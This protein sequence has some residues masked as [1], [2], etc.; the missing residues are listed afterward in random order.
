MKTVAAI[1]AVAGI[2]AS[3]WGS[4][5]ASGLVVL[6]PNASGALTLSGSSRVHIPAA[7]VYVNSVAADAVNASGRAIIETPTLYLRTGATLSAQTQP[8]GAVIHA[9]TE[10]LDPLAGMIFPDAEAL[11][12]LG[13]QSI[14]GGG[15]VHLEPG[16]YGSISINGGAQ[17]VLASGTYIIGGSGLT[18]GAGSMLTGEHV[19]L[20]IES[21]G[22]TLTGQPIIE[23]SP[24][25]EG[26]FAGIVIAQPPGNTSLMS[27][28]GGSAI[29][30]GGV[31]YAP[32][33]ALRVSGS[34]TVEGDGP[35]VGNLLIT[36]TVNLSGQGSIM[37]GGRNMRAIE[38]MRAPL[39]D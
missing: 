29:N 5:I 30:I 23:L 36:R 27:I 6:H 12:S 18:V 21:G 38:L 22:L 11:P 34:G 20:V 19:T 1:V 39:Y 14:N 25:A 2:A 10:F 17:V 35:K 28:T 9:S 31:I 3:A 37:I 15:P 26:A 8:T 33:A 4:S 32:G 13:T 16:R 7:A 24:P